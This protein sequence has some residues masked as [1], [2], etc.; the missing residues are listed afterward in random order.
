M[1][2]VLYEKEVCRFLSIP[3]IPL[4]EWDGKS[5]FKKGVAVIENMSGVFSYAVCSFD[6]DNNSEPSIKKVFSQEPFSGIKDVYVVPD[7]MER[8]VKDAD[9]DEE[10]KAAAERMIQEADNLVGEQEEEDDLSEG[11]P[12]WVFPEITSR[13]EAVAWLTNY[14]K[15]NKI[16]QNIPKKDETLKLRLLNIYSQISES[17]K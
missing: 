4:K 7:Y 17:T 14:N 16:R 9:L 8:D 10:S 11:L 1:E 3:S 15:A 6:A 2:N 13:E 12:E 5:S